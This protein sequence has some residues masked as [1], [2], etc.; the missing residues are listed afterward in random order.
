M[1]S[2]GGERN[3]RSVI[4]AVRSKDNL[5]DMKTPLKGIVVITDLGVRESYHQTLR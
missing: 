4:S 2:L 1:E 3:V 5:D